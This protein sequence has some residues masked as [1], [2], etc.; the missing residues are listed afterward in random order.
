LAAASA[1][2]MAFQAL[3]IFGSVDPAEV[4]DILFNVMC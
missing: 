2:E 1:R 3:A 4:A